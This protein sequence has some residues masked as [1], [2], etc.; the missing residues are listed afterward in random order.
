M[1]VLQGMFKKPNGY[2]GIY[3]RVLQQMKTICNFWDLYAGIARNV[4]G[5][6]WLLWDLYVGIATNAKCTWLFLD[7]YASIAFFKMTLWSS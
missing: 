7:L 4:Y 3:M 5:T 6:Q 2:Y 1:R